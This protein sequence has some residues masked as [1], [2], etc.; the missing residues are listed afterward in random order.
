MGN[1]AYVNVLTPLGG[2]SEDTAPASLRLT[3]TGETC[4]EPLALSFKE[5]K[6]FLEQG[7]E[8]PQ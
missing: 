7:R 8:F 6:I 5:I 2:M 4:F 1:R 3:G